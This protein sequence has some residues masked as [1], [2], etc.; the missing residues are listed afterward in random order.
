MAGAGGL[1]PAMTD[2]ETIN[3]VAEI[4]GLQRSA[5][6]AARIAKLKQAVGPG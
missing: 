3:R 5:V 6:I 4:D 1:G 2:A